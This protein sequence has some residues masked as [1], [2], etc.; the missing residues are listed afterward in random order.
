[1]KKEIIKHCRQVWWEVSS[2]KYLRREDVDVYLPRRNVIISSLLWN[3]I[4]RN[5][6]WVGE[7]KKA[8]EK[9][10][11]RIEIAGF[12]FCWYRE[13]GVHYGNQ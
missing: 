11:K 9:I 4:N 7:M 8:R 3:K 1:M 6:T 10:I 5:I 12:A 2:I 13:F